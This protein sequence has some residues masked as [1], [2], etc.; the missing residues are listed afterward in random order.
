M[1]CYGD[2]LSTARSH[3]LTE[4]E[5]REVHSSR[6]S[7]SLATSIQPCRSFRRR[8]L[9]QLASAQ[10]CKSKMALL[11]YCELC[12]WFHSKCFCPQKRYST[13]QCTTTIVQTPFSHAIRDNFV[14]L[15]E[16]WQTLSCK[17]WEVR[18]LVLHFSSKTA[19]SAL[20]RY[21]HQD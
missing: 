4:K 19:L 21:D 14:L 10:R 11:N 17:R 18:Q 5:K 3:T 2:S 16:Q 9:L 8:N 15:R 1:W 12:S 20:A 7:F 6:I 13:L